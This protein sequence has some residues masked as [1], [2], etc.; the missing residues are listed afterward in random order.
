VIVQYII[1]L[2]DGRTVDE[3]DLEKNFEALKEALATTDDPYGFLVIR[4]P[5]HGQDVKLYDFLDYLVIRICLAALPKLREG[6]EVV[7][8]H[9]SS[10]GSIQLRPEDAEIV[11]SEREATVG[12]FAQ[13]ELLP[14]LLACGQRFVAYLERLHGGDPQWEIDLAR[15]KATMRTAQGRK[16]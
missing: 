5:A 14:A 8:D 3:Q 1:E 7:I 15:L 10:P 12:R 9:A 6:T 11:L 13:K 2:P 16:E 4:D